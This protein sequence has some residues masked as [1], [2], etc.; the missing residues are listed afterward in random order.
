MVNISSAS[1]DDRQGERKIEDVA[2]YHDDDDDN[3]NVMMMTMA[4]RK[5]NLN[6]RLCQ[7]SPNIFLQ[8]VP[9]NIKFFLEYCVLYLGEMLNNI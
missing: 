4:K 2:R 8:C 1:V 7:V 5:K 3:V 9:K 6:A